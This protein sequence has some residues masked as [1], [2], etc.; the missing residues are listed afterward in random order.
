MANEIRFQFNVQGEKAEQAQQHDD[1]LD[2]TM[3]GDDMISNM[4]SIGVSNEAILL[5]DTVPGL[6]LIQNL[7][8]TNYVEIALDNMTTQIV[9]KLRAGEACVLMLPGS[10]VLYGKANT[11]ACV[12]RVLA[13]DV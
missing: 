9:S 2:I 1:V 10:A 7:D 13:F 5:G 12:C 4:Q 11:G 8:P 3:T 6:V